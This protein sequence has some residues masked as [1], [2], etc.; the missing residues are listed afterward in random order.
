M[1][2]TNPVSPISLVLAIKIGICINIRSLGIEKVVSI[3]KA[4]TKFSWGI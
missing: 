3:V 4:K 2:E 1:G